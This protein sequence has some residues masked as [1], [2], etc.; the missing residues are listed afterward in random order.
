MAKQKDRTVSESA[1]DFEGWAELEAWLKDVL[2]EHLVNEDKAAEVIGVEPTTLRRWR[3]MGKG[4]T[5]VKIGEA[6]RYGPP[7]IISFV[8]A[9]R[10]TSTS[11]TE[12]AA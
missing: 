8:K 1:A 10:R 6:V 12:E 3:W 11:N 5:Y 2:G 4:P 9:G 7:Q